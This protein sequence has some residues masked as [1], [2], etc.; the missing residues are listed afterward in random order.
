M[1]LGDAL[2]LAQARRIALAAQGFNDRRPSS[3]VDRRHL[4]RVLDRVGLLQLD[5][6]NVA[7][8]AH[9]MPLFSRLGPY[10]RDAIDDLAYRHRELFEYL[11]HEA[12][13]LPTSL[14]PLFRWRMARAESGEMWG[15]VA[16][17]ATRRPDFVDQVF[18]EVSERGPLRTSDIEDGPRVRQGTMWDWSDT[19]KALEWLFWAGRVA[20]AERVNF[21]R[22]YDIP[23]RVLPA[24]VLAAPTPTEDEA[25]R[26]LLLLSARHHGVGTARDLSDYYRLNLTRSKPR[27]RELVEAGRLREVSVEGWSEPAYLHPDAVLPRR[28]DARALLAPFDPVVWERT[29]AERLFDFYYRIEIYVPAPKRV[30]GYY[31]FPFLLGDRLAGRVDLKADRAAGAL[32][33]RGA[34]HEDDADPAET[35]A[36]MAGELET[37]AGWLELERVEVVDKGNLA[38][39]LRRIHR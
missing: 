19:K 7:V 26:E 29:R 2:S 17:I 18:A 9:Y 36:A 30:W 34:W 12:S 39:L 20:V 23:E 37:M 32:L 15:G 27:L 21:E 35:A 11:G 5:S 33:V 25:Q 28:I 24:D 1:P 3:R 4:R 31:V 6:V 22:R 38:P 10:P 13:L 14:H 16:T 8:R